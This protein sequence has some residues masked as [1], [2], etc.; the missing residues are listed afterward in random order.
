MAI[1]TYTILGCMTGTS[2]DAIDLSLIKTNGDDFAEEI[3]NIAYPL[4][5]KI[6]SLLL[7]RLKS[8]FK[9]NQDSLLAQLF[10][11]EVKGAME[12]FIK[13]TS[14]KPDFIAFHGQTVFHDAANHR[15]VQLG[16]P[17]Y[18]ADHLQIPVIADFRRDDILNGGYGAPL[19]PIYHQF[20]AN[21]K[22][23]SVDY[24]LAFINIGGVSNITFIQNVEPYLIA[25]DI[26]PGNALLDDWV[27]LNNSGD[28]DK[29]GQLAKSGV[30]DKKMLLSWNTNTFFQKNLPKALDRN[31]FHN[32][33]DDLKHKNTA[34]GAATLCEFTVEAIVSSVEKLLPS[35]PKMLIVCGGGAKNLTLMQRLKTKLTPRVKVFTAREKKLSNDAIEAQMMGYLAARFLNVLAVSFPETTGV[36]KPCKSGQLFRPEKQAK[37]LA[38]YNYYAYIGVLK[39]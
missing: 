21:H 37:P 31:T 9:T 25:G 16:L 12:K 4:G 22:L 30:I 1:N 3:D 19:V 20:L 38:T 14:C 11:L 10:T 23:A 33:L 15:S 26:G 18:L 35:L 24:P 8:G 13:L 7:D 34:D 27:R 36:L 29:D 39:D 6:K 32:I 17:Q 5:N 2:C 28:F